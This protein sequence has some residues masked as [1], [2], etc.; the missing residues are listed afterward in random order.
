VPKHRCATEPYNPFI[1][2]QLRWPEWTF[3]PTLIRN[4][5]EYID[6]E[7]HTYLLDAREWG[8]D[9]PAAIAHA[10]AH[11]TLGHHLINY[12]DI[13]DQAERDA[14]GLAELWLDTTIGAGMI[15]DT[16]G[17]VGRA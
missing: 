6:V 13:P 14:T 8:D 9:W 11:L 17:G 15:I 4:G 3:A 1:T 12:P 16:N 2:A 7:R 10:I 5:T